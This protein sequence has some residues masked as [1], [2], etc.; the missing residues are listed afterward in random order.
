MARLYLMLIV[1]GVLGGVGYAG[2][3]YYTNTQQKIETLTANN[4]R[5]ETAVKISEESVVTLQREAFENAKRTSELQKKLQKAEA[6]GDSLRRKLRQLDLLGDALNKPKDLEGRMNGATAKLWR[7]II[8]DTGGIP[9]DTLPEW[10][11]SNPN[12]RTESE[13]SDESRESP[14][15]NSNETET[16]TTD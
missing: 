8:A 12:T 1:L 4:A 15:T 16:S 10:L 2:Y 3:S 14:D 7:E 5:L 13:G 11:Q 9:D 6:Y